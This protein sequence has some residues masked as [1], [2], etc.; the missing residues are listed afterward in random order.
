MVVCNVRC[1]MVSINERCSQCGRDG[2]V[3]VVID[4][5]VADALVL[6]QITEESNVCKNPIGILKRHISRLR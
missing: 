5:G 2:V 1:C 3:V 6:K 4:G